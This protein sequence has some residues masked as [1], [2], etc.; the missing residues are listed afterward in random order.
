VVRTA[1]A[2][3]GSMTEALSLKHLTRVLEVTEEFEHDLKG[4]GQIEG[5]YLHPHLNLSA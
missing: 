4:T 1:Q 3:A 2:L 5:T